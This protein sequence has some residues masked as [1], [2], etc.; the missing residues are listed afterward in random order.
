MEC[1]NLNYQMWAIAIYLFATTLKGV[2]SMKLHRDLDVT[3][4][5]AWYLLHRIRESVGSEQLDLFEGTVE[6]DETYIGGK[7]SNKHSKDRLRAGRGTA[8]KIPIAGVKNRETKE[9]WPKVIEETD[10]DTMTEF[11]QCRVGEGATVYTDGSLVYKDLHREG[12]FHEA[13]IHSWGEYVRGDA[14]T[15]GIESFWSGIK[16]GYMGVYH[17]MSRKHLHLYVNEFVLRQNIRTS[18]T[19]D[20]MKEIVQGFEGKRLKYDDLIASTP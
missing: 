11:I 19:I 5:T 2:S 10:E 14:H 4:R 17:K 1:S 13:V 12:F 3:Q 16:R 18:D 20:Q 7:E 15:N 8:G 9:V 6:V